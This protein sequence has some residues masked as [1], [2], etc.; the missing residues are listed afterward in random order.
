MREA[1]ERKRQEHVAEIPAKWPLV[2]TLLVR[3]WAAPGDR[4]CALHMSDGIEVCGTARAVTATLGRE[5]WRMKD[6]E[7]HV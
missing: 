1:K 6:R 3:V 2:R 4:H 5:L 7:R